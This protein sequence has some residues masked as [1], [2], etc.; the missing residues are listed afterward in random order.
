MN[1]DRRLKPTG[2]KPE[3][4]PVEL[5]IDFLK[6][7]EETMNETLASGLEALKKHHSICD[8]K[9]HGALYSNEVLM[10]ITISHGEQSLIATTVYASA[11]FNPV[12]QEPGI[13]V[14]LNECLDS[15]GAILTHYLDPKHPHRISEFAS[16]TIGSL[17]EAPFEWTKVD[18]TKVTVYVKIDKS[19][20]ALESLADEW[21]RNND[22]ESGKEE[23]TVEA[24]DFLNERLEAI[25]KVKGGGGSGGFSGGGYTGGDS[26]PIR[27]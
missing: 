14:I 26:G 16:A 11:D 27:H 23:E 6:I 21:L 1:F 5:P 22:P 15:A 7:V 19:N 8:L 25:R 12:M 2:D 24:E 13:E 9:A 4:K 17:E 10:A 20:P 3:L 18:E